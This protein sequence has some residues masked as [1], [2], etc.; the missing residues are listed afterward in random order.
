M[1][2]VDM[3]KITLV[4]IHD[5]RHR[6]LARLMEIGAM[7]ITEADIDE[8]TADIFKKE[9][10][11]EDIRELDGKIRTLEK[12]IETL[13]P[14]DE[15]KK[16]LFKV[17]RDID[18]HDY[19]SIIF[20]RHEV[21]EKASAINRIHGDMLEEKS[22][23]NKNRNTLT[24]LGS[25]SALSIPVEMDSTPN[26]RILKGMMPAA[27]DIKGITSQID[28]Q[29]LACH[30]N[31]TGKDNEQN[32]LTV[33]VHN[34]D[35][36]EAMSVLKRN[37]FSQNDFKGFEGEIGRNMEK[38]ESDIRE[39]DA[40]INDIKESLSEH[41]EH[42]ED[43]EIVYDYYSIRKEISLAGGDIASGRRI[44]YIEGWIPAPA[45]ESLV[46]EMEE[47]FTIHIMTREPLEDE[48]IPVMLEN[49]FVGDAVQ[50]IT[51]MY[52]LPNPETVD[53]NPVMGP[54]FILF[55][56]LMFSDAGYGLV[57]AA[58]CGFIYFFVK[59]EEKMRRFMKMMMLCG[60]ATVFWGALF[61]SWFGN[62]IPILGG[63]PGRDI[64]I[65]FNPVDD[66]EYLLMWSLLFGVIHLF[67]G[68]AMRGA[69]LIKKKQYLAV[70]FDVVFWYVF[71]TGA[72]FLVLPFVPGVSA[73]L[74]EAV[75]P[76]GKYMLP[77]GGVLLILTQGRKSKNIGGKIIGGLASIYDLVSFMSDVLSYSRLLALGLATSVIATIVND[78][79][80]MGGFNFMGV[81]VFILV[82]MAGHALNFMLNA[83]G[84]YVHSSRLQYIEFF[85]K[86][87]E[88]GGEPFRPFKRN[89]KYI[90]IKD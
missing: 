13:K 20:K 26:T 22:D 90:R 60:L 78:M 85:N 25:W 28:E 11:K 66:P 65:W 72:I 71:F 50:D 69:N 18:T 4:G 89:T 10:D 31:I 6:V 47:K 84:A 29:G 54:F 3:K 56:G 53:P 39:S 46:S 73:G 35:Y 88:G 19:R 9:V 24:S 79:G 16:P 81:I 49:G 40:R 44:F 55:F 83:L 5:E 45:E 8:R 86:F 7:D 43:I 41:S 82:F 15:R 32:Y 75:A 42:L 17:R 23:I 67:T 77:I 36:E 62:L 51:E 52:S 58:A 27:A 38:I 57:M 61:G 37:G 63:D 12:A 21:L 64:S 14:F 48:K 1:A 74:A 33:F 87:Y 70:L 76:Y 2:I 34:D 68:L 30:V 59:L 80:S